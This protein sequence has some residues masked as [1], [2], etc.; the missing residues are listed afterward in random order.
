MG[1]FFLLNFNSII[2]VLSI[3]IVFYFL[4]TIGVGFYAARRVKNTSD[5]IQ[6]GRNVHPA[7][8]SAALFALWYGSETIFGA[9]AQ[10][11]EYG[12]IGIIEDPL[13]GVVCLLLVGLVFAKRLYNLNILTIGDLFKEN[14][15]YVAEQ[16]STFLMVLSF[17]GYAAA[18]IVALG[19][20]G[21]VVL[22]LTSTNAMV[23]SL[24]I[25]LI[26]TFFGGMWAVSITDFIQSILIVLG[27]VSISLYLTYTVADHT[28][29]FDTMFHKDQ[30]FYPENTIVDWSNWVASWLVLGFGS[31]VS[32]DIFQRVNSARSALAAKSS[33]LWASLFYLIFSFLPIY[34]ISVAIMIH[35]EL[36][37]QDL[38]MAIPQ[39]VL[40]STPTILQVLFFGSLMSAIMSTCSGALLAPASLMAENLIKPNLTWT[41]TDKRMLLLTRLSLVSIGLASLAMAI[42]SNDIFHLVGEA[43][44]FGLVSIFVPFCAALFLRHKDGRAAIVSMVGGSMVWVFFRFVYH[45]DFNP[46]IPGLTAS[47][48]LYTLMYS[49]RLRSI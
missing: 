29:V 1:V 3:S 45:I 48:V 4:V 43:S 22:G 41:L 20:I 31:I 36:R 37:H 13:G 28:H 32:Q 38:Q 39:L 12:F 8:N 40:N 18:Q 35:P 42:Y 9:S 49:L 24:G 2:L 23:L 11:I 47:F 10:F 30:R 46:L 7:I 34:I 21:Q 33:A 16:V 25:V 19:L 5:F 27:L 17:I 44:I 26:Y 6:A 14:Y 15:G